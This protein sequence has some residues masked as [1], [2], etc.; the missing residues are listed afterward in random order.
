MVKDFYEKLERKSREIEKEAGEGGTGGRDEEMK[1]KL[2]DFITIYTGE[3]SVQTQK[4]RK[5]VDHSQ[6]HEARRPNNNT[7]HDPKGGLGSRAYNNWLE[8]KSPEKKSAPSPST[9]Y[10]FEYREGA[11]A[12]RGRTGVGGIGSGVGGVVGSQNSTINNSNTSNNNSSKKSPLI[13]LTQNNDEENTVN[14]HNH[15]ANSSLYNSTSIHAPTSVLSV[16]TNANQYSSETATVHNTIGT[17]NNNVSNSTNNISSNQCNSNTMS[18]ANKM[19]DE[20]KR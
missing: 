13:D 8:S 14:G 3:K 2:R 11:G 12:G 4:Q 17:Y 6:W 10:Q 5:E 16:S 18:S 7:A 20:L 1:V 19:S 15:R 9:F